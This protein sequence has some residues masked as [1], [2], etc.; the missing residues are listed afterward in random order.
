MESRD[1]KEASK[2]SDKKTPKES[3]PAKR[4]VDDT[5]S[6]GG[7]HP[8][9]A[10]EDLSDNGSEGNPT[11]ALSVISPTDSEAED[12]KTSTK[13]EATKIDLPPLPD[14]TDFRIWQNNVLEAVV[15]ASNRTNERHVTTWIK[16]VATAGA[17]LKQFKTSGKHYGTLDRKLAVAVQS[18]C[19]AKK[20]EFA[21]R[22]AD[23]IGDWKK[24]LFRVEKYLMKG[25]QMLLLLYRHYHTN[26]LKNRFHS[27]RCLLTVVWKGDNQ[28]E[29]FRRDW[30]NAMESTVVPPEP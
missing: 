9:Q 23:T 4:V 2:P 12:I 18:I 7:G 11:P 28:I 26:V 24:K 13:K 16:Q 14:M 10:D 3:K 15:T 5:S 1:K 19:F 6:D 17:K 22:L 8:S 20:D 27:F 29:A 21:K 25:R 30:M